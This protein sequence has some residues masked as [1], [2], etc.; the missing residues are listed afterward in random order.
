MATFAN[1]YVRLLA[2][3]V[4]LTRE[5]MQA[6]VTVQSNQLEAMRALAEQIE[7]QRAEHDKLAEAFRVLAA[8]FEH[9]EE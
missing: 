5:A 2:Q 4:T 9:S 8:T 1:E 6:I 3:Y 7:L